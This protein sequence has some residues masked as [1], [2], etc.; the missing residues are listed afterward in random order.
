MESGKRVVFL[1]IATALILGCSAS[2]AR[3]AT[4]SDIPKAELEKVKQ[5]ATE[6][7]DVIQNVNKWLKQ[8][9]FPDLTDI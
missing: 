3:A 6:I 2:S 9:Q 8:S 7:D 4:F 1:A 5:L